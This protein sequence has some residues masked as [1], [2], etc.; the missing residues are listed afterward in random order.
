MT[1]GPCVTPDGA[2]NVS[3]TKALADMSSPTVCSENGRR[4]IYTPSVPIRLMLLPGLS[5]KRANMALR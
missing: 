2:V 1:L 4:V 5:W 3:R